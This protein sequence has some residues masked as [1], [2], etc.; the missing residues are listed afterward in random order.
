MAERQPNE[1]A[2]PAASTHRPW[3]IVPLLV[4]AAIGLAGAA[5]A[6]LLVDRAPD[7]ARAVAPG[8]FGRG[9]DLAWGPGERPAPAFSLHDQDGERI[10]LSSLGGG[11]PVLV[12]FLNTRCTDIC[13][14]QG[15]QLSDLS[16]T[17]PAERRPTIV[18]ISVNPD[19]T[20]AS[21][22]RAASSWGWQELDWH[23]LMGGRDALAP[24]WRAYGIL[25]G[26]SDA[27]NQVDHTG[28]LYL[29]D[30]EGAVR[31]VYTVPIPMPRL[32]AD[33]ETLENA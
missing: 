29:I 2:G 20:V 26:P 5:A 23:W 24:V 12:A 8:E 28:A 21:A 4:G 16:R 18:A 6:I 17:L 9:E 11:K 22:R 25:A 19:D 15:R 31:A 10:S 13:P 30:A 27:A 3:W 7:A 32:V 33:I 14:V 1:V